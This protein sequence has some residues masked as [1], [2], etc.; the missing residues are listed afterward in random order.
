MM[1]SIDF[2]RIYQFMM[3][4]LVLESRI[5]SPSY[6]VHRVQRLN[7]QTSLVVLLCIFWSSAS[8]L[9][10]FNMVLQLIGIC[11]F[12]LKLCSDSWQLTVKRFRIPWMW[13]SSLKLHLCVVFLMDCRFYYVAFC[14]LKWMVKFTIESKLKL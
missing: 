14:L 3:L 2:A 5:I 1:T 11:Q 4:S 10:A 6:S 13:G 7:Q 9:F 8:D 12:I